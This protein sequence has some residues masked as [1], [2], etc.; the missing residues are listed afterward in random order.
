[1]SLESSGEAAGKFGEGLG[2]VEEAA[3]E[4]RC[5]Q[6]Q[7]LSGH[8]YGILIIFQ[9]KHISELAIREI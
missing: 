4:P 8:I 1:M 2:G 9:L 6:R 5:G 7:T 3:V